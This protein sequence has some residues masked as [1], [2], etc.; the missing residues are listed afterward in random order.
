MTNQPFLPGF[1]PEPKTPSLNLPVRGHEVP[2]LAQFPDV[3][4]NI[5]SLKAKEL[6]IAGERFVDSTVFRYGFQTVD[7][8]E[9]EPFDRMLFAQSMALRTQIKT[10]INPNA[11]G[12]YVFSI[13]KGS[14][15]NKTGRTL[16]DPDD[17]DLL[18][19]VIL[20][21]NAVFFTCAK[22]RTI[23]IPG[24]LIPRLVETPQ[25]TLFHAVEDIRK[26]RLMS[27]AVATTFPAF[28]TALGPAGPHST[29]LRLGSVRA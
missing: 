23:T 17:F 27:A 18:A 21:K 6:S 2:Q 22:D 3:A 14:A 5:L 19:L 12:D 20:P 25:L 8:A 4:S 29:E 9:S 13:C 24:R 11:A 15:R 1:A 26:R 7:V 28:P 10:K 16:Y